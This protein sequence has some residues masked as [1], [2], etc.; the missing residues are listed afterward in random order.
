MKGFVLFAALLVAALISSL[1]AD[2]A[3]AHGGGGVV[4]RDRFGRAV[5]VDRGFNS[6]VRSFHGG[7][8]R[9]F[10]NGPAV[11]RVGPFGRVRSIR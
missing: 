1:V 2:S 11:I 5:I 10:N 9:S 3:K 4:V 7:N 6:G 8:V